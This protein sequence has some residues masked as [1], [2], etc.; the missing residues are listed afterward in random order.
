M[1]RITLPEKQVT[2]DE[3]VAFACLPFADCLLALYLLAN[4][5]GSESDAGAERLRNL[6][7]RIGPERNRAIRGFFDAAFPF[8]TIAFDLALRLPG[9]DD[10]TALIAGLRALPDAAIVAYALDCGGSLRV[11]APQSPGVLRSLVGDP[12]WAADYVQRFLF[13]VPPDPAKIVETITHPARTRER[14]ADLFADLCDDLFAPLF[15][16]LRA[17]GRMA[18]AR[19]RD[20]Y[21]RDP[22][23][24]I[25]PDTERHARGVP[26]LL[27]WPSVFLGDGWATISHSASAAMQEGNARSIAYGADM[28]LATPSPDA[29]ALT[30]P[31]EIVPEIAPPETYQDVYRLLADP[32]R[33][34]LIQLL[35]TAPR[36]GQ[37]LA[38][39]L[40]LSIATISH[41]LNGLKKLDL[42]DIKRDEHR[43]YYHLRTD[44]LRALLAGAEQQVLKSDRRG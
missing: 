10:P 14:L 3:H 23:T 32:V 6:H 38:E 27:L 2:W 37:E 8:G 19:M 30:D 20:R 35:V 34:T 17:K 16:E 7:D 12:I 41:H 40:G 13:P 5:V 44:R 28:L 22:A 25:M 36:Y 39:L 21:V 43:L 1:I 9:S 15:P 4:G 11:D 24:F 33:W 42:V 26:R 18:E 29:A 31:A